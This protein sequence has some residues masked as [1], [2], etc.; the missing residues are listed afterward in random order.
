M[1]IGGQSHVRSG[2]TSM[3]GFRFAFSVSGWIALLPS[4]NLPH[5]FRER[6]VL[7]D[8]GLTKNLEKN[9]SGQFHSGSIENGINHRVLPPVGGNGAI[10]GGAHDI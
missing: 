6:P 9:N 5:S 4:P 8:V 7:G 3:L 1:R 10:P 2:Q